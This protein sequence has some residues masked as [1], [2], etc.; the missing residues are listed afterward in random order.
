MN[1]NQLQVIAKFKQVY[2]DISKLW[3]EG[4]DYKQGIDKDLVVSE[5]FDGL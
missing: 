3:V 4:K 2:E 5:L 1:M